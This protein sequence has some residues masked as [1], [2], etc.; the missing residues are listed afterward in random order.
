MKGEP[1]R[2][3]GSTVLR[4]IVDLALLRKRGIER[5]AGTREGFLA[6][7]VS[8][9]AFP[10]LGALLRVQSGGSAAT[11][12][13]TLL[14]ALVMLLAPP[15][16]SELLARAWGRQPLWLRYATAF[17]WT[18]W[19]MFAAVIAGQFFAGVLMGL[20]VSPRPAVLLGLGLVAVYGVVL[21]WFV[22]RTGLALPGWQAVLFVLIVNFGTA[23]LFVLPGLLSG[24]PVGVPA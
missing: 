7:L 5:F 14:G 3:T 10:L 23:V 9:L 13:A 8:L 4:G 22:A 11:V 12:V 24:V 17:N 18:R 21:D 16:F 6:S 19:A 15:V 20:G 1:E 2:W